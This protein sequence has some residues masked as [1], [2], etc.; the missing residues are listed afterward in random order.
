MVDD[1]ILQPASRIHKFVPLQFV[2]DHLVSEDVR[3]TRKSF[4]CQKV[5]GSPSGEPLLSLFVP[6]FFKHS[7]IK[8]HLSRQSIKSPVLA[9]TKIDESGGYISAFH[10]IRM[11][12]S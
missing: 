11:F 12:L 8:M 9:C 2:I 6:H 1:L 3:E 7:I 10:E 5:G 4:L